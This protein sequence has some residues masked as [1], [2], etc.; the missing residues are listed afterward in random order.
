MRLIRY[1]IG[2]MGLLMIWGCSEA[3]PESSFFG[4]YPSSQAGKIPAG[5]ISSS[6]GTMTGTQYIV[7]NQVGA[8]LAADTMTGT[9]YKIKI[10]GTE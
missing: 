5:T 1:V 9:R 8:M 4:A 7:H 2:F 10:R 3:T 6:A